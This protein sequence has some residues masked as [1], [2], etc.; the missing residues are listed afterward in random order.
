[1]TEDIF[2]RLG[3]AHSSYA[4]TPAS[5]G[6]IPGDAKASGWDD[7]LGVDSAGGS[8]YM[9]TGDL[10]TAGQA[11]LQSKLISPAQ[12][13]RWFQA[14]MQTGYLGAAVGAPW[15]ITYLVSPTKHLTQYVTKDGDLEAYHSTLVL[16]P[17]YEIG[18]VGLAAGAPD[19]NGTNHAS[20]IRTILKTLVGDVIMPAVEEQAR[21]EAHSRFSGTYTNEAGNSSVVIEASGGHSGLIV[22]SLVNRGVSIV[23]PGSD[24]GPWKPSLHFGGNYTRLFPTTLKTLSR[25][26]DSDYAYE[27]RVGFRAAFHPQRFI[28][29]AVQDPCMLGWGNLDGVT[30][31]KKA[32]DDWV[33]NMSEEG[34]ATSVDIPMLRLSLERSV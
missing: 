24:E 6:V 33:F 1:M 31:G 30:Y 9:S 20:L 5:G 28:S 29:G 10:I 8:L 23:G 17:E 27:S 12:T 18:F 14:R 7:N 3:M 21:I 34:G 22:R 32:I 19:S 11:V 16:V 2:Q 13:R 4:K 15:E 25:S 26:P